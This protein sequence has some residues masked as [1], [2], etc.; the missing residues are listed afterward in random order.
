MELPFQP[1]SKIISAF[2]TP[3]GKFAVAN[4]ADINPGIEAAVRR[5]E[6]EDDSNLI[7]SNFGGWRSH[8]DLFEWPIAEVAKLKRAIGN[9][10]RFMIINA[11]GNKSFECDYDLY[12]WCN[13]NR[14]YCYRGNHNH[15]ESHWAGAY[16]VRVGE[17]THEAYPLAGQIEFKDP[18]GA[19]NMV[20]HP[21]MTSF[22]NTLPIKPVEGTLLLFPAWLYHE[23]HIFPAGEDRISISFN[24]RITAFKET[25]EATEHA[26][27]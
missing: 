9:A 10:L 14:A 6:Q 1:D 23:V 4:A 15:P 11:T 2:T 16:Y 22:G 27:E 13:I 20:P 19:I 17:Y 3:I 25:G 24:I 8:N 21:G 26:A 7:R 12:G 5:R 18:R